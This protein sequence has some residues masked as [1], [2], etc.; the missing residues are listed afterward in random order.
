MGLVCYVQQVMILFLSASI[1]LRAE[2]IYNNFC[3]EAFT[4]FQAHN[5][6]L[7]VPNTITSCLEI[8]PELFPRS[9]LTGEHEAD[10]SRKVSSNALQDLIRHGG[11][12]GVLT[13][14]LQILLCWHSDLST[15]QISRLSWPDIYF[16]L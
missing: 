14:I 5:F 7:L 4:I 1:L 10:G 2:G 11:W 9:D 13:P 3:D 8:E 12:T 16:A 15:T 6:V